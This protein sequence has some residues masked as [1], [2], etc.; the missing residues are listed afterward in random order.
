MSTLSQTR[1]YVD[2]VVDEL[3]KVTWP[4][5]AQLRNATFVMIVFVIIITIIIWLMD[6]GVRA[7]LN[8]ILNVFGGG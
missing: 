8:V 2:E 3:K 6:V 1:E 7:I 5:R 4:D